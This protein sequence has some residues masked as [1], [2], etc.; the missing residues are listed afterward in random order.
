MERI[1]D[2]VRALVQRVSEA[3]VSVD[4]QVIGSIGRGFL[5]FLGVGQGDAETNALLLAKKSALLRVFP[6]A[7]NKMNLS[8]KDVAG[9][10][11]VI[12]QFTLYADTHKGHRPA[13]TDAA[14]PDRAEH[15]YQAYVEA[16]KGEGVKTETGRF[17]ACMRVRL[18]NEGPVTILLDV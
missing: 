17:A 18:V 2:E 3:S 4:D 9:E 14:P 10:A 6:D 16:L 13:F 1:F 7:S 8:L 15:L 5:I 12:S 11:L